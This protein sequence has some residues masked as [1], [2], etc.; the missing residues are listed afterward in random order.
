M[1]PIRSRRLS[2]TGYVEWVMGDLRP[3]STMHVV[4]EVDPNLARNP[5]NTEFADSIA[6]FDVHDT[7]RTVTCDR[8]EFLGRNGTLRNPA[9]MFR[10][11][12]SGE[13]GAA[14]D[15]CAAVQVPFELATAK[16]MSSFQARSRA[17]RRRRRQ[18]GSSLPGSC[19][20]A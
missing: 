18:T 5:F 17:R 8:T 13:M 10:V 15:P 20:C 6:F 4:T 12:L 7:I 2:A 1:L 14:L 11:R 3:K 16:S 19:R 9:A